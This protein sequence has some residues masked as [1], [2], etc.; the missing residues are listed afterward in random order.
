MFAGDCGSLPQK[1]KACIIHSAGVPGGKG[2]LVINLAN[3]FGVHTC[4][5]VKLLRR[6]LRSRQRTRQAAHRGGTKCV[7]RLLRRGFELWRLTSRPVDTT[8]V[9][10][11]QRLG[12]HQ[13]LSSQNPVLKSVAWLNITATH[14]KGYGILFKGS[15]V[16]V[17]DSWELHMQE[18]HSTFSWCWGSL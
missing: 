1:H 4:C 7:I 5:H 16:R 13:V 11:E 6:S 3:T 2:H 9:C 18:L 12:M 10:A 17:C 8:D 14:S 15:G